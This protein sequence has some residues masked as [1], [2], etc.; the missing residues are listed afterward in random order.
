MRAPTVLP[1][2]GIG[3]VGLRSAGR[4][5]R[6]YS[7]RANAKRMTSIGGSIVGIVVN[8]NALKTCFQG[9]VNIQANALTKGL[10]IRLSV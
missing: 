3:Y 2:R 9:V 10:P 7:I 5:Y 8:K 6:Q 1:E 4:A